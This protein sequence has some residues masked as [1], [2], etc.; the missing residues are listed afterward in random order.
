MGLISVSQLQKYTDKLAV[1]YEQLKTVAGIGTG[2]VVAGTY[3]NL[4][5]N[6]EQIIAVNFDDHEIQADLGPN[7]RTLL[8]K[9]FIKYVMYDARAVI[10]GLSD[11]CASRG[12][13]VDADIVDLDSFLTYYNGGDG[14]PAFSSMLHPSFG[15]LYYD[16]VG[17]RL[18]AVGLFAPG[19][20]PDL[21]S[22]YTNGM[23]TRAV[24]GAF[25]DGAAVDHTL[26]EEVTLI[27]EV[28]TDFAGGATNPTL[29]IAGTDDAGAITTTWTVGLGAN[30][31]TASLSTTNTNA[32]TAHSKS[33]ILV[34]ST[35]GMVAGTVV[36][37]SAGTPREEVVVV[38]SVEDATHFTAEFRKAHDAGDTMTF[39][40]SFTL[41]PSVAGKRCRDVSNITITIGTHTDG[42]VRVVGVQERMG[43]PVS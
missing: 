39:K 23:G 15:D 10:T 22:T 24:G 40:R 18:S 8:N 43:N 41:A 1:A 35:T 7:V 30:N 2:S 16:L 13:S 33:S 31:P 19:I 28:I 17:S 20:H 3:R 42:A 27:A 36:K 4:I 37:M 34:A 32:I 9:A 14:G 25:T 21:N 6:L 29:T 12:D 38:L 5:N 26:Y 11:H